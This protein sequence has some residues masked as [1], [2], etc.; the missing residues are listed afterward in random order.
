MSVYEP[1]ITVV[2]SLQIG[3]SSEA[4]AEC[5]QER[6]QLQNPKVKL[7]R[8]NTKFLYTWAFSS[9]PFPASCHHL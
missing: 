4:K 6:Q 3:M 1:F 7:S 8:T 2:C 9:N 5:E